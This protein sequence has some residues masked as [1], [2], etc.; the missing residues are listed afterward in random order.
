MERRRNIL[1]WIAL[2]LGIIP[3]LFWAVWGSIEAFHE[4]WWKPT[5]G[6]R[7]L[8]TAQYLAPMLAMTLLNLLALRWPRVGALAYYAFGAWFSW[9]I[10]APRVKNLTPAVLLSWLPL[11]LM[12][13][14]VGLCWWSAQI[15]ARRLATGLALGLPLLAAVV[16]GA[17]PG[18]RALHRLDDGIR[19][20]RLVPGNGVALVWAPAGPGWVVDSAHACGWEEAMRTAAHLSPDG[21]TVMAT[22]QNIWRLPSVDEAVRS[23]TYRGENAGGE[24]DSAARHAHYRVQPEKE[25]PLWV[26]YSE[27]VYWWTSTEDGPERAWRIVYNGLTV[28]LPKTLGMGSQGFR[29]VR[30]PD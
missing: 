30:E 23:L 13:V 25:S 20:E 3:A 11:T 18:W 24:W 4:G 21:R 28:S 15:R 12:L 1:G 17:G 16:C 8:Q 22:P 6:G 2:S 14:L 7:L 27:T 19:S 5:L 29:A 10:L 9:F 26:P